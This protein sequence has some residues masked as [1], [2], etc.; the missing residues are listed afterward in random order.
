MEKRI[1]IYLIDTRIKS[2]IQSFFNAFS[3]QFSTF[4]QFFSNIQPFLQIDPVLFSYQFICLVISRTL[5]YSILN[6]I[7]GKGVSILNAA[8]RRQA[9]Y[10][11]LLEA[12]RPISASSLAGRFSV[13]RQV[14][15]NDIA[16]LRAGGLSIIATP[17]GY[18]IQPEDSGII[19]H[20]VCRHENP[21]DMAEELN[22]IV[23][24]G[25]SVL[26]VIVDHPIYGQ[27]IGE[28]CIASR[29]DVELFIERVRSAD[30]LP[31]SHLTEGVHTHTL[32]CPSEAAFARVEQLLQEKG[33]LFST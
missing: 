18:L 10:T 31:L 19:H 11:L 21:A 15:V 30:A 5:W 16:L 22:T 6:H 14:I 33:I 12:D 28:L 1:P 3:E 25:C 17:R 9:L 32:S 8:E 24:C 2:Q 23:D 27:L 29:F 26:N 20:I 4:L 7:P 13:S